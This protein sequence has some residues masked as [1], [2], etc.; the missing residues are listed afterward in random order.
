ME[1]YIDVLVLENMVINYLILLV[2]SKFLRVKMKEWKALLAS[3]AGTIYVVVMLVI[4]NASFY[5]TLAGK[6]ILSI[7]MILIT[8]KIK[9]IKEFLKTAVSFYISTFMFAGAAFAYIYMTGSGGFIQNGVYYIFKKSDTNMIVFALAM[10]V[11]LI[12]IFYETLFSRAKRQ[13]HLIDFGIK[14]DGKTLGLKGLIDTGNSLH[15]PISK[16]PVVVC[17]LAA[18]KDIIPPEIADIVKKNKVP[19]LLK[20]GTELS[21]GEWIPKIRLIPYSSLGKEN[22]ML[23]GFK[24]DKVFLKNKKNEEIG[25]CAAIICLYDKNLSSNNTYNALLSPD[26]IAVT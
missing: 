14:M 4:P 20:I 26:L 21:V 22:G 25:E 8:F 9:K 5:F 15:D 13:S 24:P 2:T 18:V 10:A 3:L 7:I 17:E 12:K 19:D 11:I 6:I 1:I 16:L 23:I